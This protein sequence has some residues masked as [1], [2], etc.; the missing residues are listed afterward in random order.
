[1]KK[2]ASFLVGLAIFFGIFSGILRSEDAFS[3]LEE[4]RLR[5]FES[6]YKAELN[7][8]EKKRAFLEKNFESATEHDIYTFPNATIAQAYEAYS[9]ANLN[10]KSGFSL[11]QRALPSENKAF[12]V[13]P[14]KSEPGY[15]ISYIWGNN[16]K[17]LVITSTQIVQK[18]SIC[19]KEVLEF[20]QFAKSV[21]LKSNYE[22]Y[23]FE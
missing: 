17:K 20:E 10:A 1:M 18:D 15:V 6:L 23:C 8:V 13:E 4:A 3:A 2:M 12:K 14:T 19:A 16:K 5:V 11:P 22:Q 9:K 7:S 21:V